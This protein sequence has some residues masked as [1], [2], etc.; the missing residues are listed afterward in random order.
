MELVCYI[1]KLKCVMIN[2]VYWVKYKG[3]IN[4]YLKLF[5]IWVMCFSIVCNLFI[6]YNWVIWEYGI[7]VVK[8]IK[9]MWGV[10]FKRL[11]IF[12]NIF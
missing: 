7:S 12:S 5:K 10:E 9:W 3:Y 11:M 1:C 8:V 2:D 4:V 6:V